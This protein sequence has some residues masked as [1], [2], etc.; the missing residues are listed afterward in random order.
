MSYTY[1]FDILHYVD[2]RIQTIETTMTTT[3]TTS[4]ERR[5]LEGQLAALKGFAI[6]LRTRFQ[7]KL[8]R[9]LY[10]EYVAQKT[11]TLN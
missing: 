10:R 6:F 1:F 3:N 7:K 11:R 8:P 2:D 9:R 4:M 5:H